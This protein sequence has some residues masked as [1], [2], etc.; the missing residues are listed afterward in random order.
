M[1][2]KWIPSGYNVVTP[3]LTVKD[4]AGLINFIEKTFDGTS[5]ECMKTD[6]GKVGHAEIRI[7]DS[8]IMTGEASEEWKQMPASLYI[9][10]ED[11][12]LY[13]H[14]ALKNGAT[15]LRKPADQFYGDRSGGVQDQ[16]G[17]C[18]WMATRKE[19]LSH[20]E[21]QKRIDQMKKEPAL[22]K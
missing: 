8:V 16:W 19:T 1:Q 5:T 14:R 15:S 9:Y 12:D 18:W 11:C 6:D 20:Q 13:Y 22:K 21:L 10:V 2:K 4:A 7:G 3:Y 17:N